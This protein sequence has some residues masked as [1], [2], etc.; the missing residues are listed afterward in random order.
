M[1]DIPGQK[2]F[3]SQLVWLPLV[4]NHYFGIMVLEESKWQ[5]GLFSIFYSN[6]SKGGGAGLEY[7]C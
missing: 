6:Y 2:K 5:F 4:E 1:S 7:N 3:P